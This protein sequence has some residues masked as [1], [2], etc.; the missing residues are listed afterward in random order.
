MADSRKRARQ[1]EVQAADFTDSTLPEPELRAFEET[2]FQTLMASRLGGAADHLLPRVAE[3]AP[4]AVSGCAFGITLKSEIVTG[5]L[6]ADRSGSIPRAQVERA[7]SLRVEQDVHYTDIVDSLQLGD[8]TIVMLL[9]SRRSGRWFVGVGDDQHVDVGSHSSNSYAR[10][11]L[12]DSER[13]VMCVF[14]QEWDRPFAETRIVLLRRGQRGALVSWVLGVATPSEQSHLSSLPLPHTNTEILTM[15]L[16]SALTPATT[17]AQAADQVYPKQMI[18]V[19]SP[20]VVGM[21]IVFA[22]QFTKFYCYIS[23]KF[24]DLALPTVAN[25]L[26]LSSE[27][28]VVEGIETEVLTLGSHVTPRDR[29]LLGMGVSQGVGRDDSASAFRTHIVPHLPTGTQFSQSLKTLVV[30]FKNSAVIADLSAVQPS[31]SRMLFNHTTSADKRLRANLTGEVHVQSQQ[32]SDVLIARY[33]SIQQSYFRRDAPGVVPSNGESVLTVFDLRTKQRME[34]SMRVSSFDALRSSYGPGAKSIITIEPIPNSFRW[35]P[36]LGQLVIASIMKTHD[37]GG[38]VQD[39]MF[40]MFA[41]VE[42]GR[43]SP[44][45]PQ[46]LPHILDNRGLVAKSPFFNLLVSRNADLSRRVTMLSLAY[47]P[48]RLQLRQVAGADAVRDDGHGRASLQVADPLAPVQATFVDKSNGALVVKELRLRPAQ[49]R[50]PPRPR[51]AS[52]SSEGDIVG[53][54]D[55]FSAT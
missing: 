51:S 37:Y 28:E 19:V 4:E 8:G 47:D 14:L 23:V 36:C 54:V 13:D 43:I 10:I 2:E 34:R 15:L 33:S 30:H 26:V 32:I 35:S 6:R 46:V 21:W 7:E 18:E 44:F 40:I 20:N 31:L 49:P 45:V 38:P 41:R 9:R 1:G 39:R 55:D 17:R 3:Y 24:S 5:R 12:L 53:E 48:H 16:R 29:E 25:E 50:P 22:T 52:W 27:R 11:M 42:G